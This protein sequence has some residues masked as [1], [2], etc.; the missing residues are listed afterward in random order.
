VGTELKIYQQTVPLLYLYH[1]TKIGRKQ[2]LPYIPMFLFSS[3]ATSPLSLILA[4]RYMCV[5]GCTS[6]PRR[7]DLSLWHLPQLYIWSKS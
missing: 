6:S 4:Q 2:N 3:T 5:L 7:A 1:V